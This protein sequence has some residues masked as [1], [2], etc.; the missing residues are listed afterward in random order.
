MPDTPDGSRATKTL[1][2]TA[3][4]LLWCSGPLPTMRRLLDACPHLTLF[5]LV[6]PDGTRYKWQW[7]VG[8]QP[9]VAPREL[10][11]ALLDTHSQSLQCLELDFHH[12]YDLTNP[13]LREE[14]EN[15]EDCVYTYPSLCGFESLSRMAIEFEKLV[16]V[17]NLPAS[18]ERLELRFCQFADLDSAFLA[19]LVQMRDKWCPAIKAVTVSGWE[20]GNVGITAVQER[21]RPLELSM[22]VSVDGH[23]LQILG[24]GFRLKIARLPHPQFGYSAGGEDARISGES[25]EE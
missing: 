19:D 22:R 5:K 4:E 11:E 23:V 13:E 17:G 8:Y 14:I 6:I 12:H 20:L 9:L 24:L 3:A 2:H 1:T 18:L 7:D 21:A 15:L 25:D 16:K 10:V